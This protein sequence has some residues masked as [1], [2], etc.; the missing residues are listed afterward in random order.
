MYEDNE[1]CERL[2]DSS[3][4]NQYLRQNVEGRDKFSID[5]K[6]DDVQ[7]FLSSKEVHVN[8]EFLT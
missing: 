6:F 2:L 8:I 7:D 5:I 3:D 1:L 4:M